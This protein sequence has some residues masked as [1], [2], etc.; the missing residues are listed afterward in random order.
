MVYSSF[1]TECDR[2]LDLPRKME[3]LFALFRMRWVRFGKQKDD[4]VNSS[5]I[6]SQTMVK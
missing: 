3:V 1:F 2:F 6:S 4:A 5:L